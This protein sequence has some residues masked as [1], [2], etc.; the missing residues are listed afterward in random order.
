MVPLVHAADDCWQESLWRLAKVA[1]ALPDLTI[2]ALEPFFL[3]DGLRS[4]FFFAEVA[5]NIVFDT[6][7]CTTAGM[8]KAFVVQVGAERVVYG[9]QLYSYTRPPRSGHGRQTLVRNKIPGWDLSQQEKAAILGG[10]ARRLFGA[11]LHRTGSGT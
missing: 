7:S 6:A 8:L 9:S 11:F 2:V 1:R 10:N 5:P 3:L 4:C